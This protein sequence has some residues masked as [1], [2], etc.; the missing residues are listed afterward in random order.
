[1]LNSA[2]AAR[3]FTEKTII[4]RKNEKTNP[5]SRNNSLRV[6]Q[7]DAGNDTAGWRASSRANLPATFNACPLSS[8]ITRLE[9][10]PAACVR[11]NVDELAI[12][13][14]NRRVTRGDAAALGALLD[15]HRPRLRMMV[16]LRMDRRLQSRLDASDVLQEAFLEAS[17][18]LDEFV[19]NP[20]VPF[21]IWLR[22]ITG[23][24]LAAAY[25]YHC[26]TQGR[27]AYREISLCNG[28]FPEADSAALAEHLVGRLTSPSTFA[29]RAELKLKFEDA[30]NELDAMDREII[31]LRH[32]EELT[33]AE[34]AH[35][36][37]LK[38]SAACNR[39]VR[40]LERLRTVLDD[41]P[42]FAGE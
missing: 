5:I 16:E 19:R 27:N 28:T 7:P 3:S 23:Q 39:Y 33:N 9:L 42:A 17:S 29:M 14:L 12:N 38:P 22:S 1:M 13:E 6:P 20:S 41:I 4:H 25:R 8:T 34:A 24:R 21:Y 15:L 31:V 36:L 11:C 10:T 35:L 37:D 40:A 2:N 26:G 32:F 30:L 18:R